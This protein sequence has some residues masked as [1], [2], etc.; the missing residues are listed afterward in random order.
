MS[1]VVALR[2][3]D[4]FRNIN[5]AGVS[6]DFDIE[7]VTDVMVDTFSLI[8]WSI[9]LLL[10]ISRTINSPEI[11]SYSN[12]G[13]F[14]NNI[15]I[16]WSYCESFTELKGVFF[17]R[18]TC[19]RIRIKD[20]PEFLEALPPKYQRRV[21]KNGKTIFINFC[22]SRSRLKKVLPIFQQKIGQVHKFNPRSSITNEQ[23]VLT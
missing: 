21:Q 4:I 15:L 16:P 19:L 10:I 17:K 9:I 13:I 2:V 7:I 6:T 3:I 11:L 18:T 23:H 14:W 22:N 8:A 1:A 20:F 5:R 12:E